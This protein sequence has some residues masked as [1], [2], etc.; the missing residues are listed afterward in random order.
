MMGIET[1]E[2]LEETQELLVCRE[3]AAQIDNLNATIDTLAAQNAA[4]LTRVAE[5]EAKVERL[6]DDLWH[7]KNA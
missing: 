6:D 4:L 5:L 3:L 2:T 7:A 1:P